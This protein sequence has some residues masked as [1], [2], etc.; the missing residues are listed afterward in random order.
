MTVYGTIDIKKKT[1]CLCGHDRFLTKRGNIKCAK[2]KHKPTKIIT[3]KNK[4]NKNV[5]KVVYESG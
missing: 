4:F 2:C 3:V 1:C 5:D